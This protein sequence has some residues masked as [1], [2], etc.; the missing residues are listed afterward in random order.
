MTHISALPNGMHVHSLNSHETD[1]LY[2]EVFEAEA[3]IPPWPLTMPER[4]VIV[5]VGANIGM[6]GLFARQRWPRSELYCFEPVP[7]I[8]EVLTKN[9][10][11][12][13]NVRTFNLALGGASQ[14]REITF[15]PD[16]SMMSGFEADPAKDKALVRLYIENLASTVADA[17]QRRAMVDDVYNVFES[18]L[19]NRESVLCKVER[20]DAV[21]MAAGI[22]RI[23]LLKIDVEGFEFQ[24]LDG[25]SDELWATVNNAAVEIQG[26]DSE[27]A[28]AAELFARHGLY[29]CVRQMSEYRGTN[30]STLYAVRRHE[31]RDAR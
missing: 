9:L 2:N 25:L 4:P 22:N 17:D 26:T 10:G 3:Y 27:L 5:D 7:R 18:R 19:S 6:F 31:S 20:L 28:V 23:D 15:Y 24:V 11:S 30:V 1:Y 16:Y 8:F 13:P 21:A 12:M 29:T 14:T